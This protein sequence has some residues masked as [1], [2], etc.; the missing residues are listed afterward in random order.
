MPIDSRRRRQDTGLL[1]RRLCP[2]SG[3]LLDGQRAAEDDHDEDPEQQVALREADLRAVTAS[4]AALLAYAKNNLSWRL[5][6]RVLLRVWRPA[7]QAR[8]NHRV[9][10]GLGSSARAATALLMATM[11]SWSDINRAADVTAVSDQAILTGP[12]RSRAMACSWVSSPGRPA[13]THSSYSAMAASVSAWSISC[14]DARSRR[15]CSVR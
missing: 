13:A 12:V 1:S 2:G 14:A 6:R 4:R 3:E 15:A 9:R 10:G 8:L 7:A 11:P 5:E